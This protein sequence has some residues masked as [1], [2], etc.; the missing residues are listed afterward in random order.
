MMMYRPDHPPC[1][2][3]HRSELRTKHILLCGWEPVTVSAWGLL[4]GRR[5]SDRPIC[6]LIL[7]VAGPGVYQMHITAGMTCPV[8][9]CVVIC[10]VMSWT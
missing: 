2:G 4:E 1:S 3:L 9:A 10:S 7:R 8:S 5:S 6:C